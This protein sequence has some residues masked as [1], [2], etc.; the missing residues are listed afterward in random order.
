M[1]STTDFI[2]AIELGSS[3]IAGIAGKKNSDG[4]IQVLAYAKEDSSSFIRKGIIFNLDKTAQSLTSIINK[5]ESSLDCSIG[6]VYVGIG[7]QSLHTVK[8]TIA[9]DLKEEMII[10]QELIDSLSDE[11]LST[12]LNDMEILDVAPQEYKIGNTLQVDPVGVPGSHIEGRYM[13]I[14]ARSG[15]KRNLERCFTHAKI[16]IADL[17]ISPLVTADAVL[18]EG[19]KR[20]GCA[21]VDFGA[22]T[23]TL[24]IYKGN[25]LRYLTVLPLG[26]NNITKD[27]TTLHLEEEEAENLKQAY[28]D[29]LP[30]PEEKEENSTIQLKESNERVVLDLLNDIIEAR[31]EEIVANVWNQIQLSGFEDKLLSGIVITGGG[32]NLRNI[33]KLLQQKSKIDKIRIARLPHV[34]VRGTSDIVVKNGAQ[35]T[36]IG[37]VAAGT[38]NC[39]QPAPQEEVKAEEN[40]APKPLFADDTELLRQEE[41][42]KA[43]KKKR[44]EE[45][46]RKKEEEKRKK[47]EEKR[48]RPS[49]FKD[50]VD[51]I[52][53]E[54]FSDE[55]MK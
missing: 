29:A 18:T 31:A 13:N 12:P 30:E 19:D 22:G 53:K 6:K 39:Y 26:G 38:E 14:V 17:F 11:N 25:I 1:V 15:I 7:G 48:N 3:K 9:R 46:K 51:K 35:N 36:L 21:L 27:I 2:A 43:A 5:L 50:A 10:S 32:A 54:I 20:S 45:E 23:T 34:E 16:G 55:D 28:G 47:Q 4:S 49:W 37:L 42:A 24:S 33:D 41:E 52:T 8:N 44:E 40:V